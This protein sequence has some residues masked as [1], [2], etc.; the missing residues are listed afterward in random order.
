MKKILL[1]TCCLLLANSAFA[2]TVPAYET[3]QQYFDRQTNNNYQ[4]YQRNNY[5]STLGGQN[6]S[7]NSRSGVEYGYNKHQPNSGMG[8][9]NTNYYGSRNRG[10]GGL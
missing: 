9:V 7:M 6:Y 4:H 1:L 10:F 8:S 5:Q 2:T 3:R